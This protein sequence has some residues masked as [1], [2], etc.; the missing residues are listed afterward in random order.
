MKI[1]G[2]PMP[3]DAEKLTQLLEELV[4]NTRRIADELTLANDAKHRNH[5]HVDTTI[6]A[7][8]VHDAGPSED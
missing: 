1:P 8:A 3:F 2:L 5:V 6:L 7:T 4:D